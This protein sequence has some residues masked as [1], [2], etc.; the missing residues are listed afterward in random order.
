MFENKESTEKTIETINF[1]LTIN[2]VMA[3]AISFI[4]DKRLGATLPESI[5]QWYIITIPLYL[6][7]YVIVS[8]KEKPYKTALGN[9]ILYST[10]RY[11]LLSLLAT[12]FLIFDLIFPQILVGINIYAFVIISIVLM[13]VN[14]LTP[15][16]LINKNW[17]Y[18]LQNKQ[19]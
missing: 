3:T 1:S 6:I 10:K 19:N 5:G 17:T 15:I 2:I 16:I 9:K 4:I 14:I 7:L 8:W 18:L 13:L 11:L 12:A